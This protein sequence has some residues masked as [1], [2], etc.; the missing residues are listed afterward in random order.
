MIGSPSTTFY[1]L[2]NTG[3]PMIWSEARILIQ[4]LRYLLWKLVSC[5]KL[6]SLESILPVINLSSVSALKDDTLSDMGLLHSVLS[7]STK[8]KAG[9]A[10]KWILTW[11]HVFRHFAND[12]WLQTVFSTI[13]STTSVLTRFLASA[14]TTWNLSLLPDWHL[15]LTILLLTELGTAATSILTASLLAVLP[16]GNPLRYIPWRSPKICEDWNATSIAIFCF[17]WNLFLY[18]PFL[19]YPH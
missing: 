6:F 7:F 12:M 3:C 1:A 9:S 10:I 17:H 8:F 11:H 18:C 13:I 4:S 14:S 16:C 19:T 5:Q 15:G 2:L